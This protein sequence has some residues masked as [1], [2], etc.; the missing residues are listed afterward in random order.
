MTSANQRYRRLYHKQEDGYRGLKWKS[1]CLMAEG[2]R[3]YRARLLEILAT[4]PRPKRWKA[5][6]PAAD[7]LPA[8]RQIHEIANYQRQ[9]IVLTQREEVALRAEFQPMVDEVVN[10]QNLCAQAIAR[11]RKGMHELADEVLVTPSETRVLLATSYSG[12]YSTQTR[13]SFYAE[14]YHRPW[15]V[16]LQELGCK[17]ELESEPSYEGSKNFNYKLFAYVEPYQADAVDR[18]MVLTERCRL[19]KEVCANPFVYNPFIPHHIGSF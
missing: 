13:P 17:P 19:W 3:A 12:S 6:T 8:E 9:G 1:S 11:C 7:A 2:E 14:N 4:K 15:L 16:K 18:R 10:L 5:Y